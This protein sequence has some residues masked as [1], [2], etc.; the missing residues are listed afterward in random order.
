MELCGLLLAE[1]ERRQL[2]H[3]RQLALLVPCEAWRLTLR[4][5]EVQLMIER[6][7]GNPSASKTG[8]L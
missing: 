1:R 7:A 3:D 4:Q 5:L 2:S 8:V 6:T